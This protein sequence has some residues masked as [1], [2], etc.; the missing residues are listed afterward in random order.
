M[1]SLLNERFPGLQQTIGLVVIALACT[2]V[3]ASS[4]AAG[5]SDHL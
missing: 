2:V 5:I 1:F 4:N 3:L